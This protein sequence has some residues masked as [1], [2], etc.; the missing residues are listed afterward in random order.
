MGW[1]V[2]I[3]NGEKRLDLTWKTFSFHFSSS[4]RA[5]FFSSLQLSIS[6]FRFILFSF[7]RRFFPSSFALC[8]CVKRKRFRSVPENRW[9][10]LETTGAQTHTEFRIV[11]VST[12]VACHHPSIN[13]Q[14]TQN[15]MKISRSSNDDNKKNKPPAR[16][17]LN[18]MESKAIKTMKKRNKLKFISVDDFKHCPHTRT[19]FSFRSLRFSVSCAKPFAALISNKK[20]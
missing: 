14:H 16:L 20:N 15:V 18:S 1:G 3:E 17:P 9:F 13:H 8:E 2:P 12:T 19:R 10:V 6:L 7:S 5:F 11:Y 4:A